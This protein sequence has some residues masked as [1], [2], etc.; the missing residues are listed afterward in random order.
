VNDSNQ[1]WKL[2]VPGL[3][4]DLSE[5]KA[6]WK[7]KEHCLNYHHETII[8]LSQTMVYNNK[9]QLNRDD[10]EWMMEQSGKVTRKYPMNFFQGKTFIGPVCSKAS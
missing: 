4:S 3:S 6:S 10:H 7:R 1:G 9:I 2:R 5:K 8:E